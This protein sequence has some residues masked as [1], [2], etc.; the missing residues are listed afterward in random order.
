MLEIFCIIITLVHSIQQGHACTKNWRSCGDD[1][2]CCKGETA[3]CIKRN[4]TYIPKLPSGITELHFEGNYIKV[5]SAKTF[6][7]IADLKINNLNLASNG[8]ERISR[9]T[10]AKLSHLQKLNM[11]SNRRINASEMSLSLFRIPNTIS[12]LVLNDCGLKDL[13]NNFF[14]GLNEANIDTIIL[15]N[16]DMVLFNEISFSRL[17]SLKTLDLSKN[18][19]ENFTFTANGTRAGHGTLEYLFLS[20][21]DFSYWT[22][23]FCEIIK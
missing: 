12:T 23:W 3:Y 14:D 8:I 7:N 22:P 16:N 13:P 5:L 17:R 18:W 10:F 11:T 15:Q 9:D 6:E 1:S 2:C 4:L 20:D 21:N 19:I